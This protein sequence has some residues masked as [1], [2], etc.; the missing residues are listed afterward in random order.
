MQ[1]V[2]VADEPDGAVIVA[3]EAAGIYKEECG[4]GGG[5]V[6]AVEGQRQGEAEALEGALEGV[7]GVRVR[8]ARVHD[9]VMVAVEMPAEPRV[10]QQVR[11]VEPDIVPDDV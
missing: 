3:G 7:A 1:Q 2:V 4:D 5:V 10:Q 9:G 6:Q 11:Y 8:E